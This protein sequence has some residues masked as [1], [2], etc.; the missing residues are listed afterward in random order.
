MKV[1]SVKTCL[2]PLGVMCV[3]Y[4]SPHTCSAG[5]SLGLMD[6]PGFTVAH[7]AAAHGPKGSVSVVRATE[8]LLDVPTL[9]GPYVIYRL[10]L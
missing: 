1:N 7:V 4:T 3:L 5:C 10:L 6:R 9:P 2:S 8:R